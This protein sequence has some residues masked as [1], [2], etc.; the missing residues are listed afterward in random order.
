MEA[1]E[2]GRTPDHSSPRP[3]RYRDTL[4]HTSEDWE[5]RHSRSPVRRDNKGEGKRDYSSTFTVS[6]DPVADNCF[7]TSSPC[8]LLQHRH[9]DPM[10]L[11]ASYTSCP[12]SPEGASD[13]PRS[14]SYVPVSGL[15]AGNQP[16]PTIT[17]QDEILYLG[18]A[19]NCGARRSPTA[20]FLPQ[21]TDW[22]TSRVCHEDGHR[23][24]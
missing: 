20:G 4:P 6:S 18:L 21:R 7:W 13:G 2:R 5:R 24:G 8:R 10:W 14:P 9:E 1:G 23:P 22:V 19:S 11:E 15:W 17:T 3:L 12:Y 16:A